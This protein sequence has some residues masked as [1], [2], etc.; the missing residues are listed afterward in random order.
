[1]PISITAALTALAL[2]VG[3]SSL[4]ASTSASAGAAQPP[5][6]GGQG[7]PADAPHSD[8]PP[9]ERVPS[10]LRGPDVRQGDLDS[11][12]TFIGGKRDGAPKQPRT[13]PALE[14]AAF[15]TA[16]A[17]APLASDVKANA[18]AACEDFR[19]RVAD[20]EKSAA[21]RRKKL[22]ESRR[23][24]DPAAPPS[25]E[26]KKAMGELE[27]SR[28]KMIELQERVYAMLSE[29]EGAALK[30]AYDEDLAKRRAEIAREAEAERKRKAAE[31]EKAREKGGEKNDAD[32]E[33]MGGK[34][35][36]EGKKDA[37]ADSPMR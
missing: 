24:A 29:E 18:V 26:F 34:R 10:G 5:A 6:G 33:P 15:S 13:K 36:G 27:A 22:Y 1:M 37:A 21:E 25:E 19:A 23:Q 28:P 20:W 31:R 32:G 30:K 4:A 2:L 35:G 17:A 11:E 8:A 3:P 16:V 7:A 14:F 12:G 9:P